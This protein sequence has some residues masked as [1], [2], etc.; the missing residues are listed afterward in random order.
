MAISK[1]TQGAVN[2][3]R[4]SANSADTRAGPGFET[5]E[6]KA[7]AG[8]GRGTKVIHFMVELLWLALEGANW[9]L[10]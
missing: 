9:R 5:E 2:G 7:K 6:V 3:L 8:R 4:I 10:L 1:G